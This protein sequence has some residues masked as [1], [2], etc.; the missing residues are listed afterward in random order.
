VRRLLKAGADA[1]APDEDGATPLHYAAAEG[2]IRIIR[3]LLEA[4][5]DRS[6][7][8]NNGQPAWNWA[9]G[10]TRSGSEAL[11]LL[12]GIHACPV[13]GHGSSSPPEP[14]DV[15][16]AIRASD[17]GLLASLLGESTGET[18]EDEFS[19]SPI[20][21]AVLAGRPEVIR[22]LMERGADINRKDEEGQ[23][24]LHIAAE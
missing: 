1:N 5:A 17:L 19:N 2:D 23:T 10:A 15:E 12:M 14:S 4:G 20:V 9:V 22:F 13:H 11:F 6:R 16:Q 7:G 3:L 21:T 18:S 24:L 8:D